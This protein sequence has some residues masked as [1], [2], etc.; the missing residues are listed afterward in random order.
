[1]QGLTNAHRVVDVGVVS[2]TYLFAEWSQLDMNQLPFNFSLGHLQGL[3]QDLCSRG[4]RAQHQLVSWTKVNNVFIRAF[5][6][7]KKN[8]G[9][10]N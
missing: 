9:A 3:L 10:E 6:K 5:E 2:T 1:M 8:V 7:L 4:G